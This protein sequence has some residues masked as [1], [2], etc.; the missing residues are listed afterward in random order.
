MSLFSMTCI[1]LLIMSL[2]S[3]TCILLLIDVSIL[4]AI[5][6]MRCLLRDTDTLC[7]ALL[8]AG[9]LSV[10]NLLKTKTSTSTS[11]M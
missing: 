2:F 8:A 4:Y 1:L 10:V 3:M 6:A 7:D 9:Q 5:Y 11:M